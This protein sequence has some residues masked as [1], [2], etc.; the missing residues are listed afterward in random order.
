[1]NKARKLILLVTL[2]TALLLV[3]AAMLYYVKKTGPY[4]LPDITL[5]N[6]EGQSFAL[7]SLHGKPALVVFWA[8][9]CSICMKELPQL[10]ELYNQFSPQGFE[11]VG[12]VIYYNE[13]PEAQAVVQNK[14]IPY[15]ILLD[16][17]KLATHAFGN[18]HLTP[19]T[20]LVAPNGRIVYRHQGVTDFSLI[21]EKLQK[22]LAEM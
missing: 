10:I 15:R 22:Y 8:S 16:Q 21:R 12:I 4:Y 7:R 3:A 5:E 6:F 18:V 19:T 9:T 14:G 1:M 17:K 20:F 11:I 13:P 2:P